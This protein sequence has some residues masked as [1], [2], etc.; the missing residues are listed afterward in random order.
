MVTG[1]TKEGKKKLKYEFEGES[2]LEMNKEEE[3]VNMV[4]RMFN[5]NKS[6]M[7]RSAKKAGENKPRPRSKIT[8]FECN[9]KGHYKSEYTNLKVVDE[10]PKK[11][12][13]NC[14]YK[15]GVYKYGK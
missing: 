11:E 7:R 4:R 13:K 1:T 5:K 15:K 6:F 2:D 9:S 8:C 12:R 10:K 3:L 14:E